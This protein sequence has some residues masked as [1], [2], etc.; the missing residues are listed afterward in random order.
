VEGFPL[1]N[2]GQEIQDKLKSLFVKLIIHMLVDFCRCLQRQLLTIPA[3]C[4][5]SL[6]VVTV[7]VYYGLNVITLAAYVF[8]IPS[9]FITIR[10][11]L[12]VST[13]RNCSK[14]C[15]GKDCSAKVSESYLNIFEIIHVVLSKLMP[16]NGNKF[17]G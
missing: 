10:D 7:H 16:T 13:A 17:F 15:S 11:P 8:H 5:V 4:G 12:Y 6:G 14:D 2:T 3:D 9:L 1:R